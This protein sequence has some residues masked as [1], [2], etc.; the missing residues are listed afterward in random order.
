MSRV[1]AAN[2]VIEWLQE[3]EVHR[4]GAI[5]VSAVD[6]VI[7]DAAETAEA[8]APGHAG[9][10]LVWEQLEAR[11]REDSV[12]TPSFLVFMSIATV[13]A[14]VGIL[15]DAPILI[16]GAMVVGPEYGPLAAVCVSIVRGRRGPSLRAG[17]T[18]T[19]GLV[20]AAAAALVSTVA[21]RASGL[22]PDDYVLGARE[23]TAFIARPD[24]MALVVAVLAGI[25]GMLSL[26]EGR[27]GALIG[28]LVSV[29]T[30]P[31]AAN[32]GVAAAYGAWS[33]VGGAATQLVVNLAG[34]LVAGVLTLV[35]Q[36]RTT[37]S[38]P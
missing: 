36:A 8:E 33:E 3:L 35:I 30:V 13:I 29:T 16:V 25:V 18:L 24:G 5:V 19:V 4:D 10:A 17:A 15:L 20:V 23:L 27:S 28:V 32:V 1:E 11:A 37:R 12:L 6:S 7:S 14:G 22:A 9:D 26:T 21:F 2:D 34:L 38:D 31:A